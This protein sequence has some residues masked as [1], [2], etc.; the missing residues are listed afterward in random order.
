MAKRAPIDIADICG[1]RLVGETEADLAADQSARTGR[2]PP[3]QQ[4]HAVLRTVFAQAIDQLDLDAPSALAALRLFT[5]DVVNST[6]RDGVFHE[7]LSAFSTDTV[8]MGRVLYDEAGELREHP[9]Y[10]ALHALE[11]TYRH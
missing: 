3:A 9:D 5:F 8:A 10:A 6:A 4:L 2:V 11:G 1:V 7:A